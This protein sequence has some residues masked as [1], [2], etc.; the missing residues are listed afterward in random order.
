M[1]FVFLLDDASDVGSQTLLFDLGVILASPTQE[2]HSRRV[3][4]K[5]RAS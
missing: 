5:G 2:Y 1:A 3:S 4:V